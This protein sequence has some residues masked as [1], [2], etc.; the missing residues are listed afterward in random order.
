MVNKRLGRRRIVA[1]GASVTGEVGEPADEAID[2]VGEGVVAV[3]L[4]LES[5]GERKGFDNVL[6]A[7]L[8]RRRFS[9][10][11]SEAVEPF[12]IAGIAELFGVEDFA[13]ESG[14]GAEL[15]S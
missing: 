5:R 15:S 4:G 12:G 8:S 14:I 7:T 1:I 6:V 3:E 13:G 2:F 11:T 9:S 10:R